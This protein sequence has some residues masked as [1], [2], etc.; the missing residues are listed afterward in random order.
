MT[1]KAKR[2]KAVRKMDH[3]EARRYDTGGFVDET[4]PVDAVQTALATVS[5]RIDVSE[6]CRYFGS[7]LGQYRAQV[8][9]AEEQ[10]AVADEMRLIDETEDLIQQLR[11]RLAHLPSDT[12]AEI[13]KICWKRRGEFFHDFEQRLGVQLNE[14]AALLSLTWHE[15]DAHKGNVGRKQPV[16]RDWLL[17]DVACKLRSAGIEGKEEAA[18]VA[19]NVLGA[20]GIDAPENPRKSREIIRNFDSP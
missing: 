6:F 20:V 16:A 13:N 15:L 8:E 18:G 4:F 2:A 10:P 5:D 17:H 11:L 19:A 12:G 7:R 9:S 1:I 3:D 14:A